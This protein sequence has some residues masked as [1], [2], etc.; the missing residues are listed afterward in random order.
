ML[1]LHGEWRRRVD[2]RRRAVLLFASLSP[3]GAT[4]FLTTEL[5]R[6]G[7]GRD[8]RLQQ[9]VA[10]Y[11]PYFQHYVWEKTPHRDTPLS[12]FERF[13]FLDR[14][15]AADVLVSNVLP[16]L[17]LALL[18]LLGYAGAFFSLIRYDVR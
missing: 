12:D 11:L 5:A 7:F 16:V 14:E 6:T 15:S 8:E 4:E 3:L 18:A 10:S 17:N 9:A 2:D 13:S 1:A